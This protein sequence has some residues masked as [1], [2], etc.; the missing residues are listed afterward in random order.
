MSSFASDES[1]VAYLSFVCVPHS[2]QKRNLINHVFW[3]FVL[4]MRAALLWS[5]HTIDRS[6]GPKSSLVI[7]APP[8]RNDPG[9]L[10]QKRYS[11]NAEFPGDAVMMNLSLFCKNKPTYRA[12]SRTPYKG[13]KN[14]FPNSSANAEMS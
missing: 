10:A 11:M 9:G 14:Y 8:P 3:R 7:T 2:T 4:S 5:G 12:R 1:A 13:T 6:H